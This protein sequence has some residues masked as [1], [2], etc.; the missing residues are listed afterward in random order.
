MFSFSAQH[1]RHNPRNMAIV[2]LM[3]AGNKH[4]SG[5]HWLN[6]IVLPRYMA[7]PEC[8][9][10]PG[11]GG[12]LEPS[13]LRRTGQHPTAWTSL[14]SQAADC[15]NAPFQIWLSTFI[16]RKR[17]M[18]KPGADWVRQRVFAI[19]WH[20]EAACLSLSAYFIFSCINKFSLDVD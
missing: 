10:A 1:L 17:A 2:Q 5:N 13:E 4:I 8:S 18:H 7:P 11:L 12:Q 16:K 20:R 6:H 9:E 14:G 15:T 19:G 3:Q